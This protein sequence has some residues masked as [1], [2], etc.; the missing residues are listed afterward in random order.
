MVR[1]SSFRLL[2]TERILL[3]FLLC[4]SSSWLDRTEGQCV[5][6]DCAP[7]A[8]CFEVVEEESPGLLVGN[9]TD[10]PSISSACLNS[11]SGCTTFALVDNA[12]GDA[13]HV[14]PMSGKVTTSEPIDRE[15]ADIVED[16]C[17]RP[18]V[19][20]TV[21][22]GS[23]SFRVVL[24]VYVVD[25]N[26]NAPKF[27][28][29]NLGVNTTQL[30][31]EV[32]ETGPLTVDDKDLYCSIN[33][34][35]SD[36]DE[37]NNA[38]INYTVVEPNDGTFSV[39]EKGSEVCL[40][41]HAVIDFE[42]QQFIVIVVQAEDNGIKPL[43]SNISVNLTIRDIN[44][45]SPVFQ[46]ASIVFLNVS[47]SQPVGSEIATF[48]ADDADSG[49]FGTVMYSIREDM[50]SIDL[51]FELNDTTGVLYLSR[52]QD[53]DSTEPNAIFKYEFYID[54]V[55]GGGLYSA[56]ALEIC[57]VV[58]NV[59]DH[60]PEFLEDPPLVVNLTEGPQNNST[61]I[62]RYILEDDDT[63]QVIT[64]YWDQEE[65][66]RVTMDVLTNDFVIF[67]LYVNAPSI[68]RETTPSF[69]MSITFKDNGT[70]PR[71]TMVNVTIIIH[72]INDNDPS[73]SRTNFSLV[74]NII[75]GIPVVELTAYFTDPD[76][77]ANGS[78][79]DAR[80][81]SDIKNLFYVQ[82]QRIQTTRRPDREE[83]GLDVVVIVVELYDDGD[84]VRSANQ[85]LYITILDENDNSPV[86]QDIDW[87]AL[88]VAENDPNIQ[89]ITIIE[90]VDDDL[91][92]NGSVRYSLT[93]TTLSLFHI[94][95]VTGQ[96]SATGDFD[97]ET[98]ERYNVTVVATDQGVNAT[99]SSMVLTINVT[100]TNDWS[101]EFDSGNVSFSVSRSKPPNSF[102]GRVHATDRDSG[103][104]AEILYSL[105]GNRNELFSINASGGIFTSTQFK[106]VTPGTLDL[107]VSAYN[108]YQEN[109]S[110]VITVTITVMSDD[111]TDTT[112]VYIVLGAALLVLLAITALVVL[113]F[114]VYYCRTHMKKRTLNQTSS[115]HVLPRRSSLRPTMSA[116]KDTTT[117]INS[118]NGAGTFSRSPTVNFRPD[119]EVAYYNREQAIAKS[120]FEMHTVPV[121]HNEEKGSDKDNDCTQIPTKESPSQA[122][123]I[124]PNPRLSDD[125][126]SSSTTSNP[127][128]Y[129][130]FYSQHTSQHSTVHQT[131]VL[132]E[133]ALKEHNRVYSE[134][135]GG[136]LSDSTARYLATVEEP[137]DRDDGST[138]TDVT[139]GIHSV[140]RSYYP[141]HRS[142]QSISVPVSQYVSQN[143]T[144]PS[145]DSSPNL[146]Y[147]PT[148]GASSIPGVYYS[149]VREPISSHRRMM[150]MSNDALN[151]HLIAASR[152]EPPIV[153]S[154]SRLLMP[155]SN[156]MAPVRS[157]EHYPSS[158][159]ETQAEEELVHVTPLPPTH[160]PLHYPIPHRTRSRDHLPPVQT[161]MN[162]SIS[163]M[164]LVPQQHPSRLNIPRGPFR[165]RGYPHHPNIHSHPLPPPAHPMPERGPPP[166]TSYHSFAA[167]EDNSTMAS[168]VLDQY[169]V[170]DHEPAVRQYDLTLSVDDIGPSSNDP[171]SKRP[172][173]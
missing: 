129:S 93:N 111:E 29:E 101:P 169:L 144:L 60:S 78:Y 6:C 15:L 146:H 173:L 26:D 131:M 12:E 121:Q 79:G 49:M 110:D 151:D 23:D 160:Y 86:F 162:G 84:P 130:P 96:L 11:S 106:D 5:P 54:A 124:M 150:V 18:Q 62:A 47:E 50:S 28:L 17:I 147:V 140:I 64:P 59:N 25:I 117:T 72:D 132:S 104:N 87:S 138:Y 75:Q 52:Q 77:G 10:I 166:Y 171:E 154:S 40:R 92:E 94:D 32:D 89:N 8:C 95:P 108:T 136:M 85:T 1:R 161:R 55:D 63:G 41:N 100:D 137:M 81:V 58:I 21:T 157:M 43:S 53:A 128:E 36:G 145:A 38:K 22:P 148:H 31:G 73:L 19:D 2:P 122:K 143:G 116:G 113:I 156:G 165:Q 27:P 168:S 71:S 4:L 9:L 153:T 20:V 123:H 46:N 65:Y 105:S 114:I 74:E 152:Y 44:D 30:T 66:F 13:F 48:V 42:A 102:V 83:D 170:F 119:S 126:S 80:I 3:A 135:G 56:T 70:P 155:E 103:A 163:H 68:D 142:N 149:N 91:G 99:S 139:G 115:N 112:F 57:V 134:G 158:S 45:N 16:S 109:M 82:D 159:P 118:I 97:R 7:G 51:P 90:A 61:G 164:E 34:A 67:M 33:L 88:S 141:S 76:C 14:D 37:G 107:S 133:D 127:P 172:P 35:A 167:S 125:L 39:H 69:D 24:T 120:E 98:Q